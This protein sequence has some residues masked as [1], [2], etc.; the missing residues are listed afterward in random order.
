M[1]ACIFRLLFL[2]P[3]S[4]PL[5][6]S[7]KTPYEP[8]KRV[9]FEEKDSICNCTA[10]QVNG[11]LRHGSRYPSR[12]DMKSLRLLTRKL[13]SWLPVLDAHWSARMATWN[14]P[15]TLPE[16][17]EKHLHN[18]GEEEQYNLGRRIATSLPKL[19]SINPISKDYEF[20]STDEERTL[21]SA[22]AFGLG[23]FEGRGTLGSTRVEPIAVR[24]RDVNRILR[25][26]DDC[27][28]Y[29][30]SVSKNRSALVEETFYWEGSLMKKVAKRLSVQL[31]GGR[32][33]SLL[34]VDDV[35]LFSRACILETNE[36]GSSPMCQ[37]FSDD[38][39]RIVNYAL[40]LKNFWKRS[41][42]YDINW[43][44]SSPLLKNVYETMRNKS[45]IGIFR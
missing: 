11:I 31:T 17:R 42:G 7:T 34:S 23:L 43:K 27:P 40:E 2:V 15:S 8:P 41:Y 1:I 33:Q 38:D 10:I 35:R 30:Q 18:R 32:N 14:F 24:S 44:I 28:L 26:F 12:R 5:D 19:F 25:F 4:L 16:H 9:A 22:S 36:C 29:I 37:L 3:V 39:W 21:R 6:F 13:T 45:K 20:V